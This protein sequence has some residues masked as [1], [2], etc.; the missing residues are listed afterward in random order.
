[1]LWDADDYGGDVSGGGPFDKEGEPFTRERLFR[2]VMM[3]LFP[4]HHNAGFRK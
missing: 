3:N 4:R 2:F 1:M